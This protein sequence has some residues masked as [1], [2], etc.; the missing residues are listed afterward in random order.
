MKCHMRTTNQPA[1]VTTSQPRTT[2][3]DGRYASSRRLILFAVAVLLAVAPASLAQTSGSATLRG[4]VK[5][6]TGAVVPNSTVTM[7]S[8]RTNSERKITTGDDGGFT[9]PSLDPGSYTLKVE[10]ANFKTS[11]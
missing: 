4:T 1:L 9:F 10:A 5:D 11:L 8:N 3:G 2:A 6:A 7:T